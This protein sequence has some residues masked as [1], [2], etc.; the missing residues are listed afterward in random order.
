MISAKSLIEITR[1]VLIFDHFFEYKWALILILLLHRENWASQR[2]GKTL[3]LLMKARNS[4]RVISIQLLPWFIPMT[5]LKSF[6]Q[7]W[8][9][10][11]DKSKLALLVNQKQHPKYQCHYG[12]KHRINSEILIEL[13]PLDTKRQTS[14]GVHFFNL[15]K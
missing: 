7:T 13:T 1:K 8:R 14:Q 12:K 9:T 4:F 6:T 2:M 11:M 5:V 3:E 15:V 10:E